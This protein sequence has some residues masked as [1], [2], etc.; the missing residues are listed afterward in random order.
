MGDRLTSLD[1][2]FLEIEEQDEA[3]HMHIG[4]AMVFDPPPDGSAPT[5]ERLEAQLEPMLRGLPHFRAR[6][7]EQHTGGLA[8]PSWVPDERF[9]LP[10][11]LRHAV[12][13]APGAQ[14]ELLDWLGDFWSHRLDRARPLW[15]LV[16][17]D[18]LEGGRWALVTKTHH[19]LVDGM[20]SVDVTRLLL[21][22]SPD[23]GPGA[24]APE[25]ASVPGERS[26][27]V[28]VAGALVAHPRAAAAELVRRTRGVV[29][30][31]VRDELVGA[32]H[33][34]L[35]VP[36]GGHRRFAVA[37]ADLDELKAIKAGLGGTLNDVVLA[38]ATGAL[39]AFLE[40][41]GEPLPPRG[42]RAMVPVSLRGAGETGVLGNRVSSLF[43]DLPVAIED[44]ALRYARVLEVAE[45]L[46]AGSQAMGSDSVVQAAG[47]IPPAFHAVA[48]RT[49]FSPRLFNITIT[50]VPGSRT[51]QYAFGAQ[52]RELLPLVP[53][54]ARHAAGIAVTSY[55]GGVYFGVNA[56]ADS[57]Q[58]VEVL[59]RGLEAS[60]E[61]LKAVRRI[62]P[63]PTKT[64]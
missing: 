34:S 55:A 1:A 18:G 2:S 60:I 3:S 25:P 23:P 44:P 8:R 54:F 12:L 7:S 19:C 10:S 36:I 62:E 46:K 9:D 17:L 48:V 14:R 22:A 52:M 13:P 21:D 35:D 40:H 27:P 51:P 31:L 20:S 28:R 24:A 33:T 5:L 32:P 58:D 57:V 41:R 53:V 38:V 49:L 56:D 47:L 50:N 39:R 37:S 59:A 15:E 30:L 61:E 16:L 45:S 6:L 43:V 11:H 42:L 64:G 63:Q 26:L 29:G 4:W